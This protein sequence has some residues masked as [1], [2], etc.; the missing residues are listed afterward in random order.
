[1]NM[2]VYEYAGGGWGAGI[3]FITYDAYYTSNKQYTASTRA[4]IAR[5]IHQPAR[6]LRSTFVSYLY[7]HEKSECG[8]HR[9]RRLP[10]SE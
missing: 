6:I 3:Q 1:M 10:N 7:V 4:T 5:L 2:E 8:N 9:K